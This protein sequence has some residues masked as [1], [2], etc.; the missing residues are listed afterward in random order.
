V[1]SYHGLCISCIFHF[2]FLIS[3]TFRQ[4]TAASISHLVSLLS[5]GGGSKPQ[6]LRVLDLCTGT[7]CIPLL[8]HHDFHAYKPKLNKNTSLQLVGV[9]VSQRALSLAKENRDLQLHAQAQQIVFAHKQRSRALQEMRFLQADVLRG[10]RDA[11]PHSPPGV[12]AALRI[13]SRTTGFLKL[14][15]LISNPPY[16]SSTDYVRT[17]ARSVR[18]YEPKLA[19]VP[20]TSQDTRT[21]DGDAFYPRLLEIAIQVE[22]KVVLLEV[23]DLAQAERVATMAAES[24]HWQGI[25]IWRD[26]PG[27]VSA[28]IETTT[29]AKQ[30]VRIRGSGNGR[31]VFLY[32]D[33]GKSWLS[34]DWV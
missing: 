8:F 32:R 1:C 23:A 6:N 30:I 34:R 20:P 29:V 22:A 25:E 21:A 27:A 33:Q 2:C 9:D 18:D 19:L 26:E 16:I 3:Y 17:T 7:G 4:E 13:K 12:L 5:C 24:G 10:E 28:S 15:I 31:S 11:E 14:D